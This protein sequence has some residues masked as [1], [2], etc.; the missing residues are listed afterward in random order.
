[1]GK[2]KPK[3]KP[4]VIHPCL[5]SSEARG[6]RGGGVGKKASVRTKKSGKVVHVRRPLQKVYE[7][8][9]D[10]S[11]ESDWDF[12]PPNQR[13][14]A[15]SQ[16]LTKT[17]S[18]EVPS[19]QQTIPSSCNSTFTSNK[20]SSNQT[21]LRQDFDSN[22]DGLSREPL[23]GFA[24]VQPK[25][26]HTVE[27]LQFQTHHVPTT[28]VA[29]CNK[30]M[31]KMVDCSENGLSRA[32]YRK[33]VHSR[34]SRHLSHAEHK[35]SEGSSQNMDQFSCHLQLNSE[36]NVTKHCHSTSQ[37]L[38]ESPCLHSG[39]PNSK[40]S[41][42]HMSSTS[43]KASRLT[44]YSTI[45]ATIAT[46]ACLQPQQQEVH[47]LNQMVSTMN[48]DDTN[49]CS[50]TGFKLNQNPDF[51]ATFRLTDF[52]PKFSST[53]CTKRVINPGIV[54][55]TPLQ[56]IGSKLSTFQ[57]DGH[58]AANGSTGQNEEV[59]VWAP[60]TPAHLMVSLTRGREGCK[61]HSCTGDLCVIDDTLG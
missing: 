53:P 37:R 48:I 16:Q 39:L 14:A 59:T 34:N 18:S 13:E 60:E 26:M 41:A 43:T 25:G 23:S 24:C 49:L 61:R 19:I 42:S 1:V 5:S 22:K 50:L 9:V 52:H 32:R 35:L 45:T 46:G 57:H 56:T 6:K 4:T 30:N 3:N 36:Q 55:H 7:N 20:E 44:H 40:L 38:G 29:R 8:S 10:H 28:A 51:N 21:Q 54:C 31:S 47:D 11:S 58:D 12:S 2:R 15:I 17:S 27:E 33:N